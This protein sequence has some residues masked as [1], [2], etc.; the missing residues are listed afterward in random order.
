M[1]I[2]WDSKPSQSVHLACPVKLGGAQ[3]SVLWG[4]RAPLRVFIFVLGSLWLPSSLVLL[5]FFPSSQAMDRP[6]YVATAPSHVTDEGGEGGL[7][8][9]ALGSNPGSGV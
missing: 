7:G 6:L 9:Q 3:N 4:P 1:T 2:F 8:S 5:I